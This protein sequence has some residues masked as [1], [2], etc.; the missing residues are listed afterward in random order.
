MLKKHYTDICKKY[1]DQLLISN[2]NAYD[3]EDLFYFEYERTK[4]VRTFG[5]KVA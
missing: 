2:L 1:E 3:I 5:H 4:D